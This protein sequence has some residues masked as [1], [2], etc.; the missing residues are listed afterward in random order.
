MPIHPFEDTE[1]YWGYMPLVWG[2][3]HRG[4]ATRPERAA[5]E[6]AALVAAA[7]ERGLHVWL[8]VVFNH[9]GDDG[10]AHP[11]RSLRGLDERNLYRHHSDGRPYNDSGCGN[12]VNPAHPYVREL[13][14]EG[15]Q[16]LADLG[17]DGFRF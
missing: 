2:A 4:Y 17:V 14:M 6:L 1:N 13:V 15:L 9:T 3:V 10:V 5:E 11:V 16:R 8:D 7:H 12:D